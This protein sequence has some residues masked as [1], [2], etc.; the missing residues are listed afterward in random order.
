MDYKQSGGCLLD[1]HI[2]DV[3]MARFLF[4]EPD[5][6]SCLTQN[7]DSGD[8]IV[9]SRLIY[10]NGP[11]VLAIGDWSQAG[12]DFTADYRV[13]FENA[14]VVYEQNIVTIFPRNGDKWSPIL[15]D[16]SPYLHEIEF[17][18]DSIISGAHN[19]FNPPESAAATVKL[20]EALKKSAEE[21]GQIIY[22]MRKVY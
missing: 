1:M 3:D 14:T 15:N 16:E 11:I 9:H 20:I 17:F 18:V 21:N 8:D 13:G 10:N 5:A 22:W 12:I 4:G 6:V 7:T 19:T 2:H